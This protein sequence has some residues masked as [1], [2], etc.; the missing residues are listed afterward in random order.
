MDTRDDDRDEKRRD[1]KTMLMW[2]RRGEER[3]YK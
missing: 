3:N 2:A 1:G